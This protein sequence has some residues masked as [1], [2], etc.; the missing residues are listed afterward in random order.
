MEKCTQTALEKATQRLFEKYGGGQHPRAQHPEYTLN[1]AKFMLETIVRAT[2]NLSERYGGNWGQHPKHRLQTWHHEAMNGD[3][4]LGYW[5][6]VLMR[7][8]AAPLEIQECIEKEMQLDFAFFAE[9]GI[10]GMCFAEVLL[11]EDADHPP[12]IRY[13]G[14]HF[15]FTRDNWYFQLVQDATR[16]GYWAWAQIET[17]WYEGEYEY[18]EYVD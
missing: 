7:I 11:E 2:Q 8:V 6:W 16:S 10:N 9:H 18:D 14:E 15:Y 5:Y 17:E 12:D 4:E 13:T 3:T 1:T